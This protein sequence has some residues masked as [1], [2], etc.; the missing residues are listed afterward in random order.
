MNDDDVVGE[1]L[2]ITSD[3]THEAAQKSSKIIDTDNTSLPCRLCNRYNI[4]LVGSFV[5]MPRKLY[6]R[7][8][9]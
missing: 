3:T 9:Y 2:P 4:T 1:T 6:T 7:T 5:T 8:Y